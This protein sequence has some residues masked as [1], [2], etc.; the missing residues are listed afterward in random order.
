[1]CPSA[2]RVCSEP[3][4]QKPVLSLSLDRITYMTDIVI[5][6]W[7]DI[8]TYQDQ[9]AAPQWAVA[10]WVVAQWAAAG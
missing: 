1:M 3:G 10:Q 2:P 4:G 8:R 9:L 6:P 5:Y 7:P